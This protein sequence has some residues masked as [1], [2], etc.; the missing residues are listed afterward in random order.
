MK[1]SEVTILILPGVGG[2]TDGH[3]YARWHAGLKTARRIEH[4][5]WSAPDRARY[6]AAIADAVAAA[7]KPVVLIGHALGTLAAV[8]AAP[9]MPAGKVLGAFLAALPDVAGP[10]SVLPAADTFLPLP[11]DPLP[12]PS[13]L[14]ASRTDPHCDFAVAEDLAAAWGARLVDL[15]ESGHV[16]VDSGHGPWPEGLMTF[17]KFLGQLRA[18]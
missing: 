6:T 18:D 10:G 17:G 5:D 1:A 7:D 15:R 8:H 9:A 12:F 4:D 3:W 14:L 13:L 16:D 11:R 2:G